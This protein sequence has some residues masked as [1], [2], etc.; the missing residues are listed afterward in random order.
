MKNWDTDQKGM[1]ENKELACPYIPGAE[2]NMG[3][4][5]HKN[6]LSSNE[7]RNKYKQ[8][9]LNIAKK[10]AYKRQ[11]GLCV[12]C[13]SKLEMSSTSFENADGNP[14]DIYHLQPKIHEGKKNLSDCELLC[15][16]CYQSTK[17]NSNSQKYGNS[18]QGENAM[19][20]SVSGFDDVETNTKW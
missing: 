3:A 7:E 8:N 18:L 9:F 12:C 2:D 5:F 1:T 4:S 15:K 20:F 10:K 17:H 11:G 6:S 19:N 16:A 13:G 14:E